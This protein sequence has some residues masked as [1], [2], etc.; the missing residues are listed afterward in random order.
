MVNATEPLNFSSDL[1][2]WFLLAEIQ[3]NKVI[4]LSNLVSQTLPTVGY[5]RDS[6]T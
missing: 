1:F 6:Q 2:Y 3:E 5:L 4:L